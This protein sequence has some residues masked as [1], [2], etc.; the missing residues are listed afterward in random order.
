MAKDFGFVLLKRDKSSILVQIHKEVHKIEVVESFEFS[1]DRKRMSV[2]IKWRGSYFI[3]AKGADN[4]ILERS[5]DSPFKIAESIDRLCRSGLRS[6][7]V[8][9]RMIDE[10]MIDEFVTALR[11]ASIE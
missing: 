11:H 5:A 8:G 1:S 6:L 3:Y 10:K 4:V 9:V 7:L 2:I